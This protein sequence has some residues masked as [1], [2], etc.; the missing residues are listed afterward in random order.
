VKVLGVDFTS[1]PGPR[2]AIAVARC[3]LAGARL[4]LEA[5]EEIGSFEDFERLLAEPGP[6]VGGFDFP[7]GLPRQLVRDLGWPLEWRALVARCAALS[8]AQ[9]RAVLDRYRAARPAGRKYA[10]RATDIAA[11][12]SSPMKLVNPPVALMFREGAPR[13]ARAGV[14][15]PGLAEGDRSRIALEAY[16]ALEARAIIGRASYKSDAR[17]TPARRAARRRI[18]AALSFE[19]PARLK[20]SLIE[21]ASGDSLDALLCAIQAA[22][23]W[24]RRR[25]NYGLPQN[26][27]PVEGW[28]AGAAIAPGAP[29]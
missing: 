5:I 17:D 15:V 27:D 24:R 16:P 10:H 4:A 21:D 18:V 29:Q 22:R 9:W 25:A 14:Q 26:V 13:L 28:I 3:R 11:R 8:R 20:R 23:A 12:S 19:A 2:K 1:A 7:F 6:W